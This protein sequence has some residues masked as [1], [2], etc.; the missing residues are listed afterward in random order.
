MPSFPT[1]IFDCDGVLVDTERLCHTVL[2]Q[3]L[4]EYGK[5]LSLQ[6][7]LDYF[8]GTSKEKCLSVLAELTGRPV[9]QDFLSV[10]QDRTFESFR[11]SL[12]AVPGV[13]DVISELRA[14]YCVASN[15]PHEKMRFTLGHTGLLHYFEGRIFSAEDVARPK[16]APDL[17]LHA[18]SSMDAD[19]YSCVVIEDS[20]TG[21]T[22]AKA[23]GMR[24]LGYAAM[25]QGVK[26]RAAGAD[27][28]L[29]TMV[30]LPHALQA[31]RSDA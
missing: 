6:E 1:V 17:F 30:D 7:T 22:A 9:P 31:M 15:G 10:F 26:L 28:V 18:A 3:M 13:A 5:N 20:P 11:R 19:P 29:L 25:G 4:A 14:P 16:P 27:Q 2:Q 23:A 8:M 21:I 24:V 12:V